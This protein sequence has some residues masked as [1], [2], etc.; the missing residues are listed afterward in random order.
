MCRVEAS[1]IKPAEGR[2]SP[3]SWVCAVTQV[4]R[5]FS[6]SMTHMLEESE[7]PGLGLI[8]KQDREAHQ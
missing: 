1:F 7:G 4:G 2:T 8:I 3:K 6:P 5:D